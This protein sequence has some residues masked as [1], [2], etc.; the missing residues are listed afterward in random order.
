LMKAVYAFCDELEERGAHTAVVMIPPLGDEKVGLDDFLVNHSKDD[1][2][3]LKKLA[4]KDKAFNHCKDWHKNWKQERQKKFGRGNPRGKASNGAEMSQTEREEAIALLMRKDLLLQFLRDVEKLGCAG[5]ED[6]KAILYLSY[7]SRKLT[8]PINITVKGESAAGKN[9]LVASVGKFFPLEELHFIS[10]ATPKA[11][12]YMPE[13]LSHKVVV[14]AEESGSQ[15]A[16]YSIRTFQSEGEI[17]IL[18][19][20]K[21][22]TTGRIETRERK[23]KGPVAFI[24]TTTKA[25]LHQENETRNFDLFIDESEAQ[26]K[27]IFTTHNRKYL[28]SD[29]PEEE[30][31][32]KAWRNAQKLLEPNPILIPYVEAIEFPT[33]P[34]RVRR[35]RPRFLALIEASTLLHQHQRERREIQKHKYVV[36]TLDDYEIARDLGIKILGWVLKGITPKCEELVNKAGGFQGEFTRTETEKELGWDRKTVSKYLREAV[37]LGCL[38]EVEKNKGCPTKYR[39]VKTL[40]EVGCSLLTRQQLEEKLSKFTKVGDMSFGPVN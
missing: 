30:S 17:S 12:F 13:D 16:D 34:L 38:D 4:L 3:E 18:V 36:A 35:D 39:F 5:E 32:L 8:Q 10:C 24:Q 25:H 7:T 19:P 22:K 15:E 20:E 14:I 23:V 2:F 31:F 40:E 9:F 37:G 26:T 6:N 27:A 21:D 28:G 1:F 33:M 11:F 29:G